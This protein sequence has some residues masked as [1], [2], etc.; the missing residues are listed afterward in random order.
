MVQGVMYRDYVKRS[1]VS[2]GLVGWVRNEPDRS[3]RVVAEGEES[4][5]KKLEEKLH[6]CPLHTRIICKVESVEKNLSEPTGEFENFKIT[7]T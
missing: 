2:L 1:S 6:K 3:V 4:D 5:L 7:Y